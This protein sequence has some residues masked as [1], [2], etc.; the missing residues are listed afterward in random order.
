M[1]VCLGTVPTGYAAM[2][3]ADDLWLMMCSRREVLVGCSYLGL[4]H[5]TY[6]PYPESEQFS[7]PQRPLGAKT[8][9]LDL[10]CWT[11]PLHC[12]LGSNKNVDTPLRSTNCIHPNLPTCYIRH[13][14]LRDALCAYLHGDTHLPVPV[15]RDP[16]E[17]LSM[18]AL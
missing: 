1:V 2:L 3:M 18:R 4:S 16:K 10:P 5:F 6:G 15:S 7:W 8:T 17:T 9:F 12:R 14:V 13:D 11:V